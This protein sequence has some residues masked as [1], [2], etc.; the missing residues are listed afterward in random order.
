MAKAGA[1]VDYLRQVRPKGHR[2]VAREVAL[3]G[4]MSLHHRQLEQLEQLGARGSPTLRVMNDR[5]PLE[6]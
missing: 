6:L 5:K 2:V 3:G 4:R 1:A